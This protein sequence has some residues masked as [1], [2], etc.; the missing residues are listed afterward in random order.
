MCIRDRFKPVTAAIGLSTDSFSADEDFGPSGRSWQEDSSWGSYQV[1]TLEEYA[2]AAN[3]RNALV[4]SDNIYFAKA[5]LKIGED[6]F[7]CV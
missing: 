1:T 5:A 6:N 2:G 4:Y 3:L 7:R